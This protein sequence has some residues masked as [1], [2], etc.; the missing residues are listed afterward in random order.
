MHNFTNDINSNIFPE[1]VLILSDD[2]NT[3]IVCDERLRKEDF[4]CEWFTTFAK[5][6]P[7][8]AENKYQALILETTLPDATTLDILHY[9]KDCSSN[10]IVIV[11]AEE[12]DE[13]LLLMAMQAGASYCIPKIHGY[14]E[15][16]PYLIKLSREQ[17]NAFKAAANLAANKKAFSQSGIGSLVEYKGKLSTTTVP[18][19]MRAFY[20]QQRTGALRISRDG[21]V[22]SFY[23][24]DGAVAYVGSAESETLLGEKLVEQGNISQQDLDSVSKYMSK[25][26][27]GFVKAVTTL[28]LIWLED[29]KPILVK[30]VLK[31]LYSSF[32][33]VEGEFV[34][35]P[36]VKLENEVVLSLSTADVIFAG[37]RHL[38]NRSLIEKWIGDYDRVLI[39]TSDLMSLFQALT[40]HSEEVKV[41][42][43]IDK[44]MSVAQILA[45]KGLDEEVALRTLCGLIETGML[46]PFEAKAEK[47]QV[48][49]SK[50]SELFEAAPLPQ[51]FD[52]QAAAEFCY[53]VEILL[54]KFRFC[55]HYAVLDIN[56]K[57]NKQQ[58]TEAFRELAKKFHP[59][60]HAQLASYH[61]NLKADLRTIFER[62]AQAYYTLTDDER[63]ANYDLSLK[64]PGTMSKSI[65]NAVSTQTNVSP[66]PPLSSTRP[67]PPVI[68]GLPGSDEY[69]V[70]L[71]FYRKR[72]FNQA[73]I[74]LLEAIAEDPENAEYQVALARSMLKLPDYIR[75]SE[76]A[77]L[78]AIELSPRN[79]EYCAELGLFYQ[80]F[81]QTA[82]AKAMFKRTLEIDPNNPIA[83]RVN[84]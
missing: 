14:A 80:R 52:A 33:W 6:A 12:A 31:Q 54:N 28:G 44:P 25:S 10:T 24:V 41:I 75:R 22:T 58:I 39:S 13:A 16:L 19:L 17:Q 21:I 34:F 74:L 57:S 79:A 18:R 15:Q 1:K 46:V 53:E 48:E 3:A 38:K 76:R 59:D 78:R 23:F 83:L 45:I 81:S 43:K 9:V 32:E 71:D 35:E 65:A 42:E 84:M 63:R 50:F 47:L 29:L 27:A 37:I 4:N 2:K 70:A 61:L 8:L 69:M 56:R 49:M 36:K 77:Y 26:S 72:D 62:V 68:P 5:A 66:E 20:Q 64:S 30:H 11:I 73:R 40:L 55:D 82:Q 51:D 7:Q 67:L 60:R